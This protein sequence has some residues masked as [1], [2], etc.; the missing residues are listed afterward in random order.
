M[1]IQT[2][3]GIHPVWSKSLLSTWRKLGSLATQWA[4]I[5]DWSDWADAKV[6]RVFT[7]NTGHFVGFVML[8]LIC[9]RYVFKEREYQGPSE[10][11]FQLQD[12][13]IWK[14]VSGRL[15]NN[16]INLI[17]QYSPS[18]E[19]CLNVGGKITIYM[20]VYTQ[21]IKKLSYWCFYMGRCVSPYCFA[22]D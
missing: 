14:S 10:G 20:Y 19:A 17:F 3:L 16:Q 4:N 6:D 8:Q 18:N 7:G 22:S 9:I 1:K 11:W 5:E 12:S 13:T 15:Y 21:K 2:S